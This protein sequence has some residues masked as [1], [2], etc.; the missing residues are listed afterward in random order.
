MRNDDI[1]WPRATIRRICYAATWASATGSGP[2]GGRAQFVLHPHAGAPLHPAPHA[3]IS[4]ACYLGNPC[5][6]RRISVSPR[7]RALRR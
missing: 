1:I 2:S 7:R 3:P 6:M 4:S 5:G